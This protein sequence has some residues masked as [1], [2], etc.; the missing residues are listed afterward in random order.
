M[1][2]LGRFGVQRGH[3]ERAEHNQC[4]QI[5]IEHN[6]RVLHSKVFDERRRVTDDQKD[7]TEQVAQTHCLVGS[8]W[9]R[10]NDRLNKKYL[11]PE[12]LWPNF[13]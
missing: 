12:I 2:K 9:L 1:Q 4:D 10:H 7:H 5:G 8:A 11:F 13:N 6:A 3:C